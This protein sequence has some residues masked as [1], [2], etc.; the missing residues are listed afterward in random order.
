MKRSKTDI[1]STKYPVFTTYMHCSKKFHMI[2]MGQVSRNRIKVVRFHL[3]NFQ[4]V[5]AHY[6]YTFP[7][8]THVQFHLWNW[9]DAH[10]CVNTAHKVV[11]FHCT[12]M[13]YYPS[14]YLAK[15]VVYKSATKDCQY[16]ARPLTHKI[17]KF[18]N[19]FTLKLS[20][21]EPFMSSKLFT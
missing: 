2:E 18:K 13:V 6:W 20:W 11:E 9:T 1:L 14:D 17:S 4:H 21:Y 19:T 7:H 15:Y 3:P 8:Q 12:G 5:L 16:F 10:K